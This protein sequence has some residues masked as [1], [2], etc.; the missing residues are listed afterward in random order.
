MHTADPERTAKKCP[1]S[2]GDY[3]V[4]VQ[5][6]FYCTGNTR[7]AVRV[8]GESIRVYCVQSGGI[9]SKWSVLGNV[10]GVTNAVTLGVVPTG[11][12][13]FLPYKFHDDH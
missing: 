11:V 12:P 9:A 2:D 1:I 4:N 3:E 13:I 6:G 5:G 7:T 10:D 8:E